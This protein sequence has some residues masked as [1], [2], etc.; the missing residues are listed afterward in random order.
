MIKQILIPVAAF[1]I[2]VTA[3]SAFDGGWGKNVNRDLSDTEIAVRG[4]VN[5]RKQYQENRQMV[6]E[7]RR[8]HRE[9][10][11]TALE[12]GDYD[13]FMKAVVGGPLEGVITSEDEFETYLEAHQLRQAGDFE[14]AAAL[15]GELGIERLQGMGEGRGFDGRQGGKGDCQFSERE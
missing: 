13:A 3:A 6:R 1:A 9:V 7:E 15:W 5:M 2:T 12:A 11:R 4:D 14:G 10:V 8:A